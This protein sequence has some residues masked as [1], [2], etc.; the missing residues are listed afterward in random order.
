MRSLTTV[1]KHGQ[2]IRH[3][4]VGTE[5]I[6]VGISQMGYAGELLHGFRVKCLEDG[7]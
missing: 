2:K 6:I 5:A 7:V 1:E 4:G 3:R